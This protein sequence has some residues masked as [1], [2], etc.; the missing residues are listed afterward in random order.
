MHNLLHLLSDELLVGSLG[1]ASSLHLTGGL[2][3][4]GDAEHS[5]NVPVLGLGL[6]ESLDGRVPLLDHGLSL[7]SGDLHAVEVG[8]AVEALHFLNLEGELSPGL[9]LGGQVAV[10][11]GGLEN[12]SSQVIGGV[13]ETSGLVHGSESKVLLVE[14][15]DQHVV[16]LLLGEG[17]NAKRTGKHTAENRV[18]GRRQPQSEEREDFGAKSKR[19]RV[20]ALTSSS[21]HP[22]S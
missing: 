14:A 1:V 7:V 8:I 5:K 17:M 16:P 19:S 10:G 3:G 2:L 22:S 21:W 6:H 11:Q 9:G 4:E 15:G 18:F 13:H 20:R 12:S